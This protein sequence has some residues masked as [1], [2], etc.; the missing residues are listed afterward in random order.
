MGW[1][2]PYSAAMRVLGGMIMVSTVVNALLFLRKVEVWD[3]Q[4]YS[5]WYFAWSPIFI[6]IGVLLIT[7][8]LWNDPRIVV[9]FAGIVAVLWY[10]YIVMG[11]L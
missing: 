5:D 1:M 2:F 9:V 8:S 10:V 4:F 3:H 6:F 11:G 7:G